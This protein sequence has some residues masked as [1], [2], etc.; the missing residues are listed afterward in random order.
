LLAL[1]ADVAGALIPFA[2]GLGA[3]VRAAKAAE[4]ALEAARSAERAA[5]AAKSLDRAAE[6]ARAAE[7]GADAAKATERAAEAARASDRTAAEARAAA[8]NRGRASETNI[9][10]ELGLPK[11]TQKVFTDKG[12][13]IP[14]AL[15]N[16]LSVEIKDAQRVSLTRQLQ[17]QTEAARASGRQSVLVTGE[18]TVISRPAQEAFDTI[19]RRSDLGPK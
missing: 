7:H 3:G 9:L 17:I 2:T 11:N 1:G 14:D 4:R 13:S 8:L 10:D 6:V 18:N 12:T 5:D 16:T 19:I 15:T